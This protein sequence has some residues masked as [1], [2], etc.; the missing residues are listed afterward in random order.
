[1]QDKP[2][3]QEKPTAREMEVMSHIVTGKTSQEV[4]DTLFI[5]KRT[6]DFHLCNLFRKFGATNRMTLIRNMIEAGVLC[7]TTAVAEQPEIVTT[8]EDWDFDFDNL[9][10]ITAAARKIIKQRTLLMEIARLLSWLSPETLLEMAQMVDRRNQFLTD[11][12]NGLPIQEVIVRAS[13]G[14]IGNSGRPRKTTD[15]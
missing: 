4:A 10:A 1:M 8:G 9:T 3:E 6:V 11:M 5:A 13:P 15:I 12:A 7:K 14:K 2:T